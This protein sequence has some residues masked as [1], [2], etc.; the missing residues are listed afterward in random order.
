MSDPYEPILDAADESLQAVPAASPT[1]PPDTPSSVSEPATFVPT[2]SP[3]DVRQLFSGVK[4]RKEPD[5][6]VVIE[7]EPEAASTLYA[8]FEGMAS[9]LQSFANPPDGPRP[10]G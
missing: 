5:G 7:A 3:A 2:T 8:L 6:R 9:M 4:I 1:E 10:K